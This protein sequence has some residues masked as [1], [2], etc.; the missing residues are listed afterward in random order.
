MNKIKSFLSKDFRVFLSILSILTWL[1]S[2]FTLV[3]FIATIFEGAI[4]NSFTYPSFQGINTFLSLHKNFYELYGATVALVIAYIAV[5]QYLH[6]NTQ[7]TL[8]FFFEKLVPAANDTINC[9]TKKLQLKMLT[10]NLIEYINNK[11]INFTAE[12]LNEMEPELRKEL[13][14]LHLNDLEFQTK[15]VLTLGYFESFSIKLTKGLV[16]YDLIE[17]ACAKAFCIQ[18]RTLYPLISITRSVSDQLYFATVVDLFNK[19][20]H[21]LITTISSDSRSS[22]SSRKQ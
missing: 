9:A 17:K 1:L 22:K 4:N 13:L 21:V 11:Q 8:D 16:N 6:S 18:V 2:V 5:K 20:K 3:T 19:W 12:E 14:A 7:E 10:P 15:A